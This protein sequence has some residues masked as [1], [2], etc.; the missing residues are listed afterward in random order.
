M[1][2]GIT[3][4]SASGVSKRNNV[5]AI[6][7]TEK[8]EMNPDATRIKVYEHKQQEEQR[9]QSQYQSFN[10]FFAAHILREANN[11]EQEVDLKTSMKAYAGVRNNYTNLLAV[12]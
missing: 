9:N 1:I 6:S 3:S 12:V 11:L 10:P 5:P 2:N 7:R 8:V 4:Y